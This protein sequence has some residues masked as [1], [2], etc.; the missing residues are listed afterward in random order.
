MTLV[1][2]ATRPGHGR[3]NRG[4]LFFNPAQCLTIM[5]TPNIN[6]ILALPENSGSS[7]YGAQMG[8]R[9]IVGDTPAKLHLQAVDF[10]DG[11]YDA[12]GAYW[13]NN[14][15]TRVWCAFSKDGTTRV[16]VRSLKRHE[17][18]EMVQELLGDGWTFF[19]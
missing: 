18:K 14:G 13:G 5:K 4:G 16:F 19:K 1:C 15:V 17:A 8:R 9:N 3:I 11:D 10:I 7:Q 6:T 2:V 12:G